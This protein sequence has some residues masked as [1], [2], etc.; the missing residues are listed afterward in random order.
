MFFASALDQISFITDPDPAF[1][2]GNSI[3]TRISI[4]GAR[5]RI[6]SHENKG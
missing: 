6:R 5:I 1:G 3:R 4:K 2:T